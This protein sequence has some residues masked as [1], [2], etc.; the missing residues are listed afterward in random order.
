MPAEHLEQQQKN[1]R[2]FE[3]STHAN[4][5]TEVSG[6]R[7]QN[8]EDLVVSFFLKNNSLLPVFKEDCVQD[9]C[10]VFPQAPE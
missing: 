1:L 9:T 5:C 2:K 8:K 10:I 6:Q 7:L 3:I 4:F